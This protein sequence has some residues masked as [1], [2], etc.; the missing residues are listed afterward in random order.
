MADDPI[1]P[2]E[3][4]RTFTRYE[5][6]LRALGDRI[7]A[8]AEATV[9][10]AVWSAQYQAIQTDLADLRAAIRDGLAAA[11]TSALERRE[12]L[13][14]RDRDLA[15]DLTDLR[16]ELD[17]RFRALQRGLAAAR[18]EEREQE[19]T[20]HTRGTTKTA[21]AIAAIAALVALATLV[22]SLMGQGGR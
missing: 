2:G 10:A 14:G 6:H 15:Q 19:N 18:R 22:V 5:Q 13:Q 4:A 8:L 1:T 17:R 3:I 12:T 21:N 11:E 20:R 7:T 9:P 16:T